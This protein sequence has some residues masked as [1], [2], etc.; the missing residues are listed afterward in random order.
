[1]LSDEQQ[2][3]ID[4]ITE[5][6]R[7]PL[8]STASV[9]D[10]V[11]GGQAGEL[12]DEP[13]A[14]LAT[15][16]REQ[17][18]LLRMVDD[19]VHLSRMRPPELR[20]FE[21]I[22]VGPWLRRCVDALCQDA[23]DRGLEVTLTPPAEALVVR[24]VPAQLDLAVQQLL[25]NALKFSERGGRIDVSAGL[26]EGMLRVTV[27]DTGIGFDGS[28]APRMLDCFARATSAEAARVPGAG[29]GLFLVAEIAKNHQGRVWLDSRRDEGT[30]AHLA[31]PLVQA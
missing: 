25:D 19:L 14:Y 10:V 12:P 26:A 6:L 16:A 21:V 7:S 24:G 5:E 17:R 27:S 20:E 18:R 23:G 3:F 1:V 8:A 2:D 30:Q 9:L 22:P 15:A 13:H 29:I 31:L 28:E 11:L 4:R